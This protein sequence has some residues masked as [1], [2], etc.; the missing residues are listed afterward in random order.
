MSLLGFALLEMITATS[1]IA[2]FTT[3]SG[4]EVGSH[5]FIEETTVSAFALFEI[6]S[7]FPRPE[8]TWIQLL[9]KD[10]TNP[11]PFE[12]EVNL[13][14]EIYIKIIYRHQFN[15]AKGKELHDFNELKKAQKLIYEGANLDFTNH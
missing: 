8:N 2:H 15:D 6:A 14:P 4:K 10:A 13:D 3:L 5:T 12:R 11:I 1:T 9:E 7:D